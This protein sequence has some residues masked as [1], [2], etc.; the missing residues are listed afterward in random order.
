[1]DD[2]KR[3][4]SWINTIL[5]QMSGI[6][7]PK[8][9]DILEACGKECSKASAL[10]VGALDVRSRHHENQDLDVLFKAFKSRYYNTPGFKKQ[11]S[12]ITL[13]FED[14]TCPLVKKGV[15]N[16]FLCHCT[17]GYSRQIFETLFGK[18]VEIRLLK[19]ILQGDQVCEQEISIGDG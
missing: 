16:P 15:G 8:G 1:M 7:A 5:H 9:G 18:V 17:M 6:D 19:S 3:I 14:C 13:I 11:G 2:M 10:L 4:T 12:R